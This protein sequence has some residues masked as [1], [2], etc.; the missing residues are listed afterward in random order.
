MPDTRTRINM[1]V[2]SSNLD[3]IREA[4][5]ANG[6]D[7]TSFV[8]GAALERARTVLLEDRVTRLSATEAA[9]LDAALDDDGEAAPALRALLQRA[10]DRDLHAERAHAR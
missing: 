2:E 6:Q 8:L 7:M 3:L 10:V 9:R 5:A 4:A 1:R